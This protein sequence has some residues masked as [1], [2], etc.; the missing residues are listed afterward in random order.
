MQSKY[1][2][3]RHQVVSAIK[4]K[5]NPDNRKSRIIESSSTLSKKNK[6]P[7]TKLWIN[8]FKTHLLKLKRFFLFN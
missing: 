4:Q 6:N 3:A 8:T 7:E 2:M 5:P 1:G